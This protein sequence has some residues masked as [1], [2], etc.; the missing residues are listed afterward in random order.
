[1]LEFYSGSVP[2]NGAAPEL[3]KVH[4][5]LASKLHSHS[6]NEIRVKYLIRFYV[7]GWKNFIRWDDQNVV[8]TYFGVLSF[9]ILSGSDRRFPDIST[10]FL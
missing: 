6:Q 3:F 4:F 2:S 7:F 1:M 9:P 10:D 5:L 8:S